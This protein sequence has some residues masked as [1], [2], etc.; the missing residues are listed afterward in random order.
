MQQIMV[1]SEYALKILFPLGAGKSNEEIK[2][3]S[4]TLI[5]GCFICQVGKEI[6]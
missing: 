3:V 2:D 4:F 5:Y 6:I 1:H